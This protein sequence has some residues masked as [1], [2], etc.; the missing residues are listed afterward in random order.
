MLGGVGPDMNQR[1]E[2]VQGTT[3]LAMAYVRLPFVSSPPQSLWI[4]MSL[5]SRANTE[6]EEA[7]KYMTMAER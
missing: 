7:K 6:K 1:E 4:C 3:D 5:Y 2:M